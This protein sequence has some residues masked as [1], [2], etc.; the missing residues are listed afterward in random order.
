M[1]S[2]TSTSNTYRI[3]AGHISMVTFKNSVLYIKLNKVN[4]T[5]VSCSRTIM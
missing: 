5:H 1:Q 3:T 4:K 2:Y